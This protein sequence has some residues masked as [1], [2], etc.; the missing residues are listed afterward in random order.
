[1]VKKSTV[2]VGFSG[3]DKNT[4]GEISLPIYVEGV[5]TQVMFFVIECVSAYNIILGRPWI[6]E[7]KAIP[8]SYHQ[9][10][11]FPTPWGIQEIKVTGVLPSSVT[12]SCSSFPTPKTRWYC[13]YRSSLHPAAMRSHNL[14]SWTKWSLTQS[15]LTK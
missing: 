11:K 15:S 12:K 9:T 13:N 4:I 5:N 1:M 14:N 10:V 7:L 2:L 8:S 3:E 6:H